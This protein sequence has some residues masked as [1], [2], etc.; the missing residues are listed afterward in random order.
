[1]RALSCCLLAALLAGCATAPSSRPLVGRMRAVGGAPLDLTRLRGRPVV[2][3]VVTTWT[4]LA[5][6]Q[7]PHNKRVKTRFGD[8]V[9]LLWVVLEPT[10]YVAE[11]F[12]RSFE[13]PGRVVQPLDLARFAGPDGPLG[14]IAVIPSTALVDAEGRVRRVHPGLWRSQELSEALAPLLQP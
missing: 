7:V 10:P 11:A 9:Q 8:R 14:E 2:V 3:S 5:L 6:A 12:A 13:P 4:N 1:M